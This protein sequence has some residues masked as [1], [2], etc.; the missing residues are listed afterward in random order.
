MNSLNQMILKCPGQFI[1]T[2]ETGLHTLFDDL[3]L[4]I[5]QSSVLIEITKNQ[6]SIV[7][8]VPRFSFV[9]CDNLAN[10]LEIK[11]SYLLSYHRRSQLP[12]T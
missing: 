4:Y 6:F 8:L 7:I 11:V 9:S 2:M 5:F 3:S 1:Y 12:V 10:S